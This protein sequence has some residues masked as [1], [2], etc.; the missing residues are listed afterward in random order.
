V[1][2]VRAPNGEVIRLEATRLGA[3]WKT[4]LESVAR[5]SERLTAA[6]LPGTE[7]ATE[8]TPTLKQQRGAA[9]LA[10]KK[11]DAIFGGSKK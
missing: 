5:F 8:P 7:P 9:A 3:A 1:K 11:A 10:S 2:G 4:S 6:S